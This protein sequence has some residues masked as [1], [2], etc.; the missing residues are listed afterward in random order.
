MAFDVD[1]GAMVLFGGNAK[2]YGAFAD[3][4]IW[5]GTQWTQLP[6]AGPPA[7][8]GGVMAFHEMLGVIVMSGGVGRDNTLNDTWEWDGNR[9]A[10]LGTGTGPRTGAAMT[11]DATRGVLVQFGGDTIDADGNWVL[12]SN[13]TWTW[14]KSGWS[15]QVPSN[16]PLGRRDATLTF[17]SARGTSLLIGGSTC[18]PPVDP[19]A[20]CMHVHDI[21]A[22]DGSQ[23]TMLALPA[24]PIDY[25]LLWTDKA[26]FDTTRDTLILFAGGETWELRES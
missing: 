21:W 1:R 6:V 24:P 7:R 22:W 16:A 26:T 25:R 14:G 20:G 5:D 15:K 10:L 18:I 9:W 3:T 23:W 4:W 8:A 13:D 19:F 12:P 17:D 2:P 11:Y